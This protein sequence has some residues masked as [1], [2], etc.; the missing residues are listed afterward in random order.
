[1]LFYIVKK[2]RATLAVP[3]TLGVIIQVNVLLAAFAVVL[4]A[5][6]L[7]EHCT[8]LALH[9]F[10]ASHEAALFL[11]LLGVFSHLCTHLILA[12]EATVAVV[13]HD[14]EEE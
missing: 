1:M 14:G 5:V 11:G 8:L 12:H 3:H 9:L 2:G 10:H 7:L 6:L 13:L 4:A